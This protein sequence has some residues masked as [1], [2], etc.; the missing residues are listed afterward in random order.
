M[1]YTSYL[2]S[3][4]VRTF[5]LSLYETYPMKFAALYFFLPLTTLNKVYLTLP[6][7]A[8]NLVYISHRICVREKSFKVAW[9]KCLNIAHD[10]LVS[11]KNS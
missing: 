11:S 2:E 7:L 4:P 5:Q 6:F 10:L 9:S 8:A 3:Y 1:G